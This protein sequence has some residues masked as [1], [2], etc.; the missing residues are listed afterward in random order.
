[1]L[2]TI[3]ML[4]L[5]LCIIVGC[6][7]MGNAT[8]ESLAIT[9]KAKLLDKESGPVRSER[10]YLLFEV[11]TGETLELIVNDWDV[12]NNAEAEKNK[13]G[14]LTYLGETFIKF[15]G[16]FDVSASTDPTA[17]TAEAEMP[18]SGE[19]NDGDYVD[20]LRELCKSGL[21]TEAEYQDMMKKHKQ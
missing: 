6:V 21:L 5:I 14:M 7:K 10:R 18:P 1:M 12:Y 3:I 20:G 19:E 4:L 15:E 8:D 13:W 2:V 9:V 17:Q 16:L 11:E